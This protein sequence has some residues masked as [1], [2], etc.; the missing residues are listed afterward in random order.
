MKIS[1]RSLQN[2]AAV[3]AAA[4][5][6]LLFGVLALMR[7]PIQLLPDTN[8]PQLFVNAEWREAAPAELEEALIEPIEEVMRGLP[9]LVEMRSESNRG[10]GG[11]QL[12]FEVGTD[13]TRVMLDVVSRLN[14]LPPLPPDADEPQ[15][16]GGDN[17][18]TTN[19]ASLLLRP[20]AGPRGARHRRRIPA[21]HRRG[22]SNRGW[23]VLNGVSRVSLESGRPREVHVELRSAPARCARPL[24]AAAGADGN[25]G[26][27]RVRRIRQRRAPA[28]HRAGHR[29]ASPSPT[30]ATSSSAGATIGRCTCVTSPT[31]APSTS[32]RGWFSYRSGVP[33]YYI[34]LQR[35]SDSNTVEVV[36]DVKEAIAEL[37]AGP[38][39]E[40]KAV[41]RTVLGCERLRAPRHRLRRGK[42]RGRHPARR[43]RPLVLPARAA[44]AARDRRVD[45][46]IAL[47]RRH[48]AARAR[49]HAQCASR[50]RVSRSRP[51]SSSM[52]R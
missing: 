29:H 33:A 36:D 25:R 46:D 35:T 49:A 45:P 51:A 7:L 30:S 41:R 24:A 13:M 12:T 48:H 42:P 37:N 14:T 28:V 16:F 47:L 50:W 8:Q 15:V 32:R 10:R 44:R 1:E 6:V 26:A 4:A 52:R 38:A 40:G 2:P 27:R 11:V 3:A 23:H 21:I 20:T 17:F 34:T 22:R 39:R 19:A 5:I 31:S 9:G 18:Q 43:R